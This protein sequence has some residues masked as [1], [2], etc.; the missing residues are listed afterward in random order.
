MD[1]LTVEVFT[2][3]LYMAISAVITA[4]IAGG[5]KYMADA[6]NAAKEREAKAHWAEMDRI[7]LQETGTG[8]FQSLVVN[9]SQVPKMVKV[10]CPY[11][12]NSKNQYE[13]CQ[14]C[15]GPDGKPS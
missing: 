3:L 12:G 15:G 8:R 11:C 9:V 4:L 1:M 14:S 7:G 6:V 10:T 2:M 13:I 5:I